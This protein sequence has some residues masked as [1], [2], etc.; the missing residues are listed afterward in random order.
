MY[1]TFSGATSGPTIPP[2]PTIRTRVDFNAIYPVT[3]LRWFIPTPDEL[4][5]ATLPPLAWYAERS[6]LKVWSWNNPPHPD[7]PKY[8]SINGGSGFG[9][10]KK[11][12]TF[13]LSAWMEAVEPT[14]CCYD[15]A[16]IVQL[17]SAVCLTPNQD[18][19]LASTWI[20]QTPTGYVKE[21]PLYG[22]PEQNNNNPFY[23]NSGGLPLRFP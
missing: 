11:G 3:L 23:L 8:D 22:Q 7:R 9:V 4:D 5:S 14:L 13:N 12:G 2:S 21:G 10:G 16:A 17:A 20:Y 19:M 1:W 18:E 6:V 15:L